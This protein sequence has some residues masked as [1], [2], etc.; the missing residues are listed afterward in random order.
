MQVGDYLTD[1]RRPFNLAV[2]HCFMHECMDF[3]G[4]HLDI[5]LRQAHAEVTFPGEAQKVEKMVEV[6]SRRYI[7]CN[8][9]FVAG[10]RSPDT[11]FVLAYAVVLLNT[12][13]HSRAVKANR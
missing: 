1:L 9:M 3:S 8:Q 7:A 2:L 13:L 5:A 10:F 6:F 4:L 11:I 12:D